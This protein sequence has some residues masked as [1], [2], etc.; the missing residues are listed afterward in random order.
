MADIARLIT[1]HLDAAA[2]AAQPV[3]LRFRRPPDR[4]A[5]AAAA[6][7]AVAAAL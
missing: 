5:I 1:R 4:A 6:V 3:P 7:A 2:L